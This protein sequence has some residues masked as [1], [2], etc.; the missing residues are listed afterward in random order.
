MPRSRKHEIRGAVA[1]EFVLLVPILLLL[2]FGAID[3][4]YYF[5][6]REVVVNAAREGA[7]AGT[8][9]AVGLDPVQVARDALTRGTLDPGRAEINT[10]GGAAGCAAGAS[11]LFIRYD[12]GSLT[13]FL[14]PA[15]LPR[16]AVAA[17]QMR[18]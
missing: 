9:G 14:P 7:R 16:Y 3:W 6:A 13:G 4:G 2:V 15:L 17:A 8:V 11:C 5:V 18:I 10:G 12:V 1:V